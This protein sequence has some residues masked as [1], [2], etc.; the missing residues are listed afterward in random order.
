MYAKVVNNV[1]K[2]GRQ[3]IQ[4]CSIMYA[5]VV[6]NVCKEGQQS[7]FFVTPVLK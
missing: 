1:C 2:G 4:K 7:M 5:K 3:Y 6:N